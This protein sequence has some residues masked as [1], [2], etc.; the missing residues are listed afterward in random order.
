[1]TTLTEGQHKAE[2][3]VTEE[4]GTLSRDTITVA[5]GQNLQA[6]HV[7]G[8]ITVGT[9]TGAAVSGNVGNGAIGSVSAGSNAKPGVY[10][11]VC[12]EAATNGGTFLVEDPNGVIIGKAVVGT[13]FAGEV[14]FALADGSTDFVAGDRFA[15]TVAAGS[16]KYKEYNPANT[17]GSET[18][19]ALL[20]DNVD[21]T[22]ADV[23]AVAITRNVEVNAAELVWF[24]GATSDQKNTGLSQL[25][26]QTII[27]RPAI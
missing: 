26:A 25:K 13:P 20:L 11:T 2:F 10:A 24:S 12:V 9:A 5:H 21:A 16:G 19:V 23:T 4:E 27:A 6:G 7:L 17:D 14:N 22:S 1:M 18:A 3:L 15:I 8:K